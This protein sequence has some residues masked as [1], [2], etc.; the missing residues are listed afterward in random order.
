MAIAD[1]KIALSFELANTGE[2]DGVAVPQ[3]YVRDRLATFVRPVKEV[4]A[5]CHVSLRAGE[6]ATV[7]FTVPVDMLCFTGATGKRIVERGWFDLMVGPSSGDT[8]LCTAVEVVGNAPR[9]ID[10][11]WRMESHSAVR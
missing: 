6:V 7:V 11:V 1:G 3:L 5:F 2:R 10:R 4:K 8:P 9:T